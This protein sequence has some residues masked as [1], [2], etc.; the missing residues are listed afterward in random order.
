MRWPPSPTRSAA[1]GPCSSILKSHHTPLGP[2]LI[3]NFVFNICGA[4][5]RLDAGALH[6]D[7]RRFHPREGRRR[8]RRSAASP[9]ASIHRSPPCWCT[10][11]SAISSPAS[12]STTASCA[13]TNS[14]A[15]RRTCA[16]SWASTSSPSMPAS[17]FSTQLAGVTDPETKRKTHRRRIHR[18]LRRRGP[19]HRRG[20]RRCRLAG[21]GHALS[22]CH[23]VDQRQRPQPDHQEPSQRGRPAGAHEAQTDRA[24]ARS[25]QGRS[26]PHRPRHG[27]A[28]RDPRPPAVSRARPRRPHPRRSHA[29]A[30]RACCRKPTT[31]SSARSKP[32]ASTARSGRAS[33]S[34][35]R[36]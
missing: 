21:A 6:R 34:C 1:S 18:R 2:Q 5:R 23:R 19:A 12:S 29:R 8:T 28:R 9:A 16:T 17:A 22:R 27:H 13:R 10:R 30:R 11:P 24:A 32:P 3:K 26:P 33:P 31:S 20:N 36:S 35:F 4:T 15:C 7:H 14:K 25:V